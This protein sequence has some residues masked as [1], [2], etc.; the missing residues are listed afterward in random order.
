MNNNLKKYITNIVDLS[1]SELTEFESI[2]NPLIIKKGDY[3][4]KQG[5]N[6]NSI[7]FLQT[8]VF[9]ITYFD[10]ADKE[11]ILEFIFENN[12]VTDYVSYLAKEPT[13]LNLRAI[14]DTELLI[15]K[16][17]D[18]EKLYAKSINFQKLGRLIAENYFIRFALRIK[19]NSLSPKVRYQQ[20]LK[21]NRELINL[22]PQYKI[23]SYLGISAEWLSKLRSKK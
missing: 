9:E 7:G 8:G 22:I 12:F 14:T 15:F 21:E 10:K 13:E 5:K 4:I 18:V 3:F 11:I 6:C 16:N 1:N 20:M 2:L 19:E 23:A 17:E